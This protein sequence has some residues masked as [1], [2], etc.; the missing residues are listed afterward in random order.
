MVLKLALHHR[1][2][3]FERGEAELLS[4]VRHS[5]VSQ[6]TSG[7][8]GRCQGLPPQVRASQRPQ[9]IHMKVMTLNILMGGEDRMEALLGL[10]AHARPDVLVLQECLG[11]EDGERLR[12]VA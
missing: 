9:E 5:S 7:V 1:D 3:R 4:R 8:G 6:C 10:L 12:Q 11:W 2:S